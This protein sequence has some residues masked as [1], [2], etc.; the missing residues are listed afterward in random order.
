MHGLLAKARL[1]AE[2]SGALVLLRGDVVAGGGPLHAHEECDDDAPCRGTYVS[3]RPPATEER[4]RETGEVDWC[5]KCRCASRTSEGLPKDF[6]R[7]GGEM[8]MC[9]IYT[10]S[11][12]SC[13]WLPA[14]DACEDC[15]DG[16]EAAGWSLNSLACPD[17]DPDPD[18]RSRSYKPQYKVLEYRHG[19]RE[20]PLPLLPPQSSYGL[21]AER[22]RRWF[23]DRP[24]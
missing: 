6:L 21:P 13:P 14:A 19:L 23:S 12:H 3:R 2:W 22:R 10:Y 17:P 4:A 9:H 24:G 15:C 20:V 18:R 7:A 5:Q 8:C 16:L 11:S 1:D